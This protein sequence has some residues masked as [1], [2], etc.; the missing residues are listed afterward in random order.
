MD[1][2]D[3]SKLLWSPYRIPEEKVNAF[4]KDEKDPRRR[5]I[6]LTRLHEANYDIA[7][8]SVESDIKAEEHIESWK[9][10]SQEDKDKFNLCM[11][12]LDDKH[13]DRV[14]AAMS[15][16]T[17]R[18]IVQYY[19]GVW[20]FTPDRNEWRKNVT[21]RKEYHDEICDVCELGGDL[22]CCDTCH[23]AF[24]LKCLSPPLETVPDEA[25]PWHCKYCMHELRD[26]KSRERFRTCVAHICA[27]IETA[28]A[29]AMRPIL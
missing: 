22:I 20:K 4:L 28:R 9:T 16:K 17:L 12:S 25:E 21:K 10:W 15:H 23:L 5:E 29:R 26:R 24:H 2:S 1:W 13:F 19:Y 7:A 14:Q 18:E 8:V 3:T 27:K 11:R 6:L